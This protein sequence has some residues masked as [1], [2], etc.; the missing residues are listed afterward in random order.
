MS[1]RGFTI[2]K[3]RRAERRKQAEVRQA[4]Y[5]KLSL[6]QK[7][8]KLPEG[9]SNKQ[10]A[11]LIALIEAKNNPKPVETKSNV[12][13]SQSSGS[14]KKQETKKYMKDHQDDS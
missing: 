7:L 3:E 8:D 11:R 12:A 10:R 13:T 4:E 1:T 5:D 2:T 14:P 6:Q 9:K